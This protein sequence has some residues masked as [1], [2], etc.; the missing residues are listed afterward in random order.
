MTYVYVLLLTDNKYY[1][2]KTDDVNKIYNIHFT[3]SADG[4]H[5]PKS[6]LWTGIYRPIT[7]EVIYENTDDDT[8]VTLQYM[9][10]KGIDNVRGGCFSEIYLSKEKKDFINQ[11]LNKSSRCHF[12]G[13]SNHLIEKCP[14][15]NKVIFRQ[16]NCEQMCC[17][18]I[19]SLIG[20]FINPCWGSFCCG[21]IGSYSSTSFVYNN[22]N[23]SK[24]KEK[25]SESISINKTF[26]SN[27]INNYNKQKIPKSYE[28]LLIDR[29]KDLDEN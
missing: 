3:K 20:S 14:E 18:G 11:L 17:V 16:A 27:Y 25:L 21:M 23:L 4:I 28:I 26:I 15:K 1:V 12:C 29:T 5:T 22:I 6:S 19:F 13:A 2:G 9:D 7:I 8:K 24:Y 10:K